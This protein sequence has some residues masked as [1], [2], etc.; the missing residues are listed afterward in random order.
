MKVMRNI[1]VTL[2]LVVG[3]NIAHAASYDV[4][5]KVIM[6]GS[7]SGN[8]YV[9]ISSNPDSCAYGGIYFAPSTTSKESLAIALAAKASNSPIRIDYNKGS[10]GV[11]NGYAIYVR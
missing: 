5:G 3:A 11:C 4:G 10:D 1:F 6:V 8:I 2:S 7:Q 9:G